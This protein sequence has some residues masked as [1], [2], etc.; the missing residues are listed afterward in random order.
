MPQELIYTSSSSILELTSTINCEPGFFT[1]VFSDLQKEVEIVKD[2]T[3]CCP[4]I[5]GMT[6]RK[7]MI[8]NKIHCNYAGFIDYGNLS[9]ENGEEICF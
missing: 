3:D 4:M 8:Y 2:Y 6:I 5:D 9:V 1:E 7:Q